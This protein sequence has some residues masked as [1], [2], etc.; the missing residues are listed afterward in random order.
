MNGAKDLL[1]KLAVK[2]N[3]NSGHLRQITDVYERHG[4][5]LRKIPR[6]SLMWIA[7]IVENF[8]NGGVV[9][10]VTLGMNVDKNHI[11]IAVIASIVLITPQITE[12]IC[13]VCI[14]CRWKKKS[15]VVEICRFLRNCL[16]FVKLAYNMILTKSLKSILLTSLLNLL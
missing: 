1:V 10:A 2:Q 8:I 9:C 15:L 6:N 12:S 4:Y 13:F 16:I 14:S 5:P 3:P 7:Q 11:F